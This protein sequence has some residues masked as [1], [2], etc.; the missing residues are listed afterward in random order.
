VRA[1]LAIA[2]FDIERCEEHLVRA[3]R[4]LDSAGTPNGCA[5]ALSLQMVRM[6]HAASVA[7]VEG[8]LSAAAAAEGLLQKQV[9]ERLD[10]HPELPILIESSKGAAWLAKGGSTR[11]W[12]HSQPVQALQIDPGTRARSFTASVT[13]RCWRPCVDSYGGPATFPGA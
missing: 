7:N 3:E 5:A 2:V 4:E 10:E 11:R 13:S 8:A 9:P 1:A 12:R 6:T